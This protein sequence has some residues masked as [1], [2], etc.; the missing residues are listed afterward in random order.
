MK[1]IVIAAAVITLSLA[2]AA[3]AAT[4]A[5]AHHNNWFSQAVSRATSKLDRPHMA[6]VCVMRTAPEPF[7]MQSRW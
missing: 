2:P 3:F 6:C 1:K 4:P 5:P 7:V